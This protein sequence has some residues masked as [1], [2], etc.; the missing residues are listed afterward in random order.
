MESTKRAEPAS[1]SINLTVGCCCGG[2]GGHDAGD[3]AVAHAQRVDRGRVEAALERLHEKVASGNRNCG[4]G[5]RGARRDGEHAR[6]AGGP[7]VVERNGRGRPC[8]PAVDRNLHICVCVALRCVSADQ[9]EAGTEQQEQERKQRHTVR[10]GPRAAMK[11]SDQ[12]E[13]V[14][15]WFPRR[16]SSCPSLDSQP[17]DDMIKK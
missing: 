12:A 6:G 11:G 5:P 7:G 9:A 17:I 16:F 4:A 2:D 13:K 15:V 3:A 10:G 1:Q 14:L 8:K